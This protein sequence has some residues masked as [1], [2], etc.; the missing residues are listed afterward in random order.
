MAQPESARAAD[1]TEQ[2]S[3]SEEEI[4]ARAAAMRPWLIEEQAAT[5][6]RTF[7]SE[8]VHEAFRE[9][10]FYRMHLPKRYGGL[11]HS[12]TAYYRVIM[13][14]SR[15]CPSTG[16]MLSLGAGHAQQVAAFWPKEAQDEIFAGGHFVA[17]ASFVH[18]NALATPVD[19]GYLVRGTW[20]FC[21]GVPHA[22]HHLGLVPTKEGELGF[23]DL[24]VVVIPRARFRRLDNWGDLIG[25]KGSG[26]HSVVVEETFIPAHYAIPFVD[27]EDGARVTP[28]YELHRN[29]LFGGRFGVFAI[30][31]LTAVQVG[32]A[33]A[34]VD[35]FER[36][37]AGKR[38]VSILNAGVPRLE[39]HNY[40]RCLGLAMAWTDAAYSIHVQ[41][42][43]L[44]TAYSR[45][46]LEGGAPF[47][48]E[49]EM[50]LYGQQMTA[51]RL[52]WEAGETLFRAA[53]TSGARDGQRM[54]RYWRDLCAFRT[55]G[56]H[57]HDFRAE[58][59]AQTHLGM[60]AT[61]L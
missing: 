1:E 42:G 51:A 39:E 43:N 17:S 4:V 53:S 19:G 23:D 20:H 2:P 28:G 33:Q 10:G 8:E 59:L 12:I 49:D 27:M 56:I 30:G 60:P 35:E 16:W 26:S 29:P 44:Y 52:C 9:A 11:E 40:Q 13:E 36:L 22:T 47:G 3:V 38:T 15:G 37:L 58:A 21:S 45:R 34:M 50:R 5:E 57:Q 41:V 54:Q 24:I 7:Y 55:N 32:N 6:E 46:A 31:R 48:A 25:L 18:E 61:F 14:V